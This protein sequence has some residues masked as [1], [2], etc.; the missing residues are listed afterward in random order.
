MISKNDSYD[1]AT[2]GSRIRLY[3][4]TKSL[5]VTGVPSLYFSPERILKVQVR[6]SGEIV[7]LDAAAPSTS[8]RSPSVVVGAQVSSGRADS[9][10]R[11]AVR[12][13]SYPGFPCGAI[14]SC[15]CASATGP[16]STGEEATPRT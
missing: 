2:V 14:D 6:P 15:R 3:E 8:D 4:V 12:E 13:P 10:G 1:A 11:A 16:S 9:P 5:A 7:Q